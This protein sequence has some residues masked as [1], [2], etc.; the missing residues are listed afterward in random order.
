LLDPVLRAANAFEIG[1]IP[2][3]FVIDRDG[4][5]RYRRR[6]ILIPGELD[7]AIKALLP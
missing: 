5:I 7:L 3:T 2:T 1:S 4:V 6:G